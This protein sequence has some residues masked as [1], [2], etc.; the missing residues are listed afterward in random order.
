MHYVSALLVLNINTTA[1]PTLP[2]TLSF[3]G[4]EFF[5]MFFFSSSKKNRVVLRV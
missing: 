1:M 5:L 2:L 3:L 4:F